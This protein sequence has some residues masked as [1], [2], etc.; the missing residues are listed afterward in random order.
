MI[1]SIHNLSL[2][3]FTFNSAPKVRKK[4]K[5]HTKD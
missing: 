5:V 4:Q 1:E 3:I 2:I